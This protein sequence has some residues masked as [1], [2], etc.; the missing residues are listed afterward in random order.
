MI[1]L[2]KG[3]LKKGSKS[4]CVTNKAAVLDKD[5]NYNGDSKMN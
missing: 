2:I 5:G 1:N 3:G 4:V